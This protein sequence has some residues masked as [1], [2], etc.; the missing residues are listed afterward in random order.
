M[1]ERALPFRCRSL[2][3]SIV[4]RFIRAGHKSPITSGSYTT[5]ANKIIP[6]VI[7]GEIPHH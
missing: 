3:N 6:V 5:D 4:R 7:F 2:S 1:S